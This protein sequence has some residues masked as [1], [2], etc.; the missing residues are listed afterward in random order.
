MKLYHPVG[1]DLA[2]HGVKI[3][4]TDDFKAAAKQLGIR[5]EDFQI[6]VVAELK[7]L[8]AE[9]RAQELAEYEQVLG[10]RALTAAI[11]KTKKAKEAA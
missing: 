11:E 8:V 4:R 6:T 10:A 7:R 1:Y 3:A 5:A 9:Q 2:N